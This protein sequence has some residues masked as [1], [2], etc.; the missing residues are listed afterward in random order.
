L[1]EK[2]SLL[3]NQNYE[4]ERKNH[5][6]EQA[7]Q[8]LEEKA[9]QLAL[10]SKYKSEFLANMSHELRTP[11]NSML[12]LSQL[13]SENAESNLNQKQIEYAQ[14]IHSSGADLLV[15]INDVLD[16]AKIESGTISPSINEVRIYD[17]TNDLER[18]FRQ[19][20]N[21]K[22]LGFS[23]EID[24]DTIETIYTDGRRLQQILKNLLSNAFKFTETGRVSLKINM[25]SPKITHFKQDHLRISSEVIAFSVC[26]TGI[27]IA[28]DKQRLIFEAFQQADGT[29]SRKYGGTGL[30]LSISRELAEALG[31][32]IAV[33]SEPD[34]GSC[35]TLYLPI[36]PIAD[37]IVTTETAGLVMPKETMPRTAAWH[38]LIEDDRDDLGIGKKVILIVE[39]DPAFAQILL[40]IARTH[41]YKGILANDGKYA[42]KLAAEYQPDAI[43]LD[44]QIPEM[45]GWTVLDRLKHNHLTRHI[46]VHIISVADDVQRGLQR[47]AVA[48]LR[49][50]V[51]VDELNQIFAQVQTTLQTPL[52]RIL[53]VVNPSDNFADLITSSKETE[54]R[55]VMTGREAIAELKRQ[56]VDCMILSPDLPDMSSFELI[57]QMQKE[58]SAWHFPIILYAENELIEKQRTEFER[59]AKMITIKNTRSR[60]HLVH[61]VT[62]FLH[63]MSSELSSEQKE[64]LES[65]QRE[66]FTLEGKTILII[67]DDVRN[68][69]AITSVLERYNVNVIYALDG[70]NGIQKLREN[71]QVDLIL[72]DI[73]MP[74]MDGYEAITKIR[75]SP[76]YEKLPIIVLTAKAMPDDRENSLRVGASDYITKPVEVDSLLSLLRVHLQ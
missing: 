17:M 38:S 33:E 3:E 49:K 68:I 64:M 62:L 59:L 5:E 31:G 50:P 24:K 67:D 15:L 23:I 20:A 70:L 72:M 75:Q 44:I 11:L 66:S 45:D 25:V 51:G 54:V 19:I 43:T 1:E 55:Y 69:F 2:A 57:E 32:E 29:T 18:S 48:H 37:S 76:E 4:V 26:D 74:N 10:S 60:E 56:G 39:D 40:N 6:I 27:G 16:L 9:E 73:M 14:T 30:G 28:K 63:Q 34:Q 7:K 35:F 58:L 8:D 46:P 61:D 12:I 13:L 47:G 52:K 53:L 42:L 71:E 65:L 36:Q 41:G 22:R 21:E